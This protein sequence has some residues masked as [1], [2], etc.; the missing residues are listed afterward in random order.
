MALV[1]AT[2]IF[3]TQKSIDKMRNSNDTTRKDFSA[4]CY[5][6]IS[7]QSLGCAV[8]APYSPGCRALVIVSTL[9]CISA[10][11]C[12]RYWLL[13]KYSP[14]SFVPGSLRDKQTKGRVLFLM[15]HNKIM[16]LCHR[17]LW[18]PKLELWGFLNYIR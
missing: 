1:W 3:R 9:L 2:Q 13:G 8:T 17:M 5:W 10:N 11:I 4:F 6:E 7:V 12:M 15:M 16:E 18:R 14:F